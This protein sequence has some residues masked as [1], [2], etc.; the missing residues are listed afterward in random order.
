MESKQFTVDGDGELSVT[1][2][3]DQFDFRLED[4]DEVRIEWE[5]ET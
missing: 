1:V 5:P 2:D 4:G 3:G